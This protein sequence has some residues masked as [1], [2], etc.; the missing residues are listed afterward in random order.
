MSFSPTVEMDVVL[1]TVLMHLKHKVLILPI[2]KTELVENH[3][4]KHS[5][6]HHCLQVTAGLQHQSHYKLN[7]KVR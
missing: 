5:H 1:Y 6:P 7:E 4:L 2:P 3:K